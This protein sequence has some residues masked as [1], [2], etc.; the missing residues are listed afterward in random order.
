MCQSS[1]HFAFCGGIAALVLFFFSFLFLRILYYELVNNPLLSF[2]T[3][4]KLTIFAFFMYRMGPHISCMIN[5]FMHVFAGAP[6]QAGNF[7]RGTNYHR[8]K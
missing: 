8:V 4:M 6:A 2:S 1:I 5:L 7:F 3:L